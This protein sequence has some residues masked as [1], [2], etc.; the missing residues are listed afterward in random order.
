MDL[1]ALISLLHQ[2]LHGIMEEGR[3]LLLESKANSAFAFPSVLKCPLNCCFMSPKI[4]TYEDKSE[5]E[6]N[7]FPTRLPTKYLVT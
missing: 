6:M 5:C 2:T 7:E 4:K 1:K 3:W